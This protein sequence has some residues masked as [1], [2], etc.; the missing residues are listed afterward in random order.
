MLSLTD[1]RAGTEDWKTLEGGGEAVTTER[2]LSGLLV[3][4]SSA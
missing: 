4:A 3:T 1:V 2:L